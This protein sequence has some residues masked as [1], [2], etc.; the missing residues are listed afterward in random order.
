MYH[1]C[2][3][4]LLIV[5]PLPVTAPVLGRGVGL[6]E[7]AAGESKVDVVQRRARHRH[8]RHRS[9][10][11]FERL[12]DG[13]NRSRPVVRTR[14]Q[15]LAV[16]LDLADV[17]HRRE[18]PLDTSVEVRLLELDRD[19]VPLQDPFQLIGGAL[20]DHPAAVHDHQALRQ[21]VGLLEVVGREQDRQSFLGREARDLVPHVRADLQVEAGRGLVEEQHRRLVDEAERDVEPALHP[22]GKGLHDPVR[23][24]RQSEPVEE[25]GDAALERAASHVE[26][27]PLQ[28]QVLA[29]GRLPVHPRALRHDADGPPDVA[30]PIEDVEARDDRPSLVGAREGGQDLH[31][32]RLARAV[33]TEHP[34]DRSGLDP[35]P[36]PV[37]RADVAR[38][39]LDEAF[40]LDGV[41]HPVL[42][43]SASF[44]GVVRTGEVPT[45]R[46]GRRAPRARSSAPPPPRAASRASISPR[47]RPRS[48]SASTTRSSRAG[49]RRSSRSG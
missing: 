38:V 19:R 43:S 45:H 8:A 11:G 30:R 25:L 5:G 24:L 44:R 35:E 14:P 26:E 17:E 16:E 10:A 18:R 36:D 41:I 40:G 22:A 4:A 13:G 49:T 29:A 37:Q 15:G 47:A 21:A 7:A 2:R 34:E 39:G 32:R 27:L 48:S 23:S 3:R 31:G 9:A 1:V 46:R 12:Q 33:R 6:G 28:A 42:R 20:G